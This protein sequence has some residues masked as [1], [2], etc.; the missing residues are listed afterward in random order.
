MSASEI[1]NSVVN[2]CCSGLFSDRAC[3]LLGAAGDAKSSGPECMAD[4]DA[5]HD[6]EKQN[7]PARTW[8]RT[9]MLQRSSSLSPDTVYLL[10]KDSRTQRTAVVQVD[11]L[12]TA[13]SICNICRAFPWYLLSIG[14]DCLN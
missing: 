5:P 12:L 13:S 6:H 2:D 1:L 7:Q 9:S 14:L 10:S 11:G 8:P 4:C 3:C